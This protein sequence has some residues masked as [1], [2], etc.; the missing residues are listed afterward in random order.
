MNRASIVAA[1]FS[2]VAFYLAAPLDTRAQTYSIDRFVIAGGSGMSA[3]GAFSV[4]GTIGQADAGVMSGGNY[5]L[6]GG[7]WGAIPTPSPV[8]SVIIRVRVVG[9]EVHLRF[10][11]IP[12]RIYYVERAHSVTGPWLDRLATITMPINGVVEFV[13]TMSVSFPEAFYRTST[14]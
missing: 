12:G 5:S 2:A 4:S 9:G 11:G 13:H 8:D 10:T 14:D 7:F 6:A 1:I 3:G